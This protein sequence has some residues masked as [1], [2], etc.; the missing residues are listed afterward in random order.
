[1]Y[2]GT[3]RK[4]Y[5]VRWTTSK[6]FASSHFN[7]FWEFHQQS[8]IMRRHNNGFPLALIFF[9][10]SLR[11]W[12]VDQFPVGSSARI[13]S[14]FQ[15]STSQL[16]FSSRKLMRHFFAKISSPLYSLLQFYFLWICPVSSQYKSISI[17][18]A[19]RKF[20]ILKND[21]NLTS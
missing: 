10:T 6:I 9:K 21:S 4:H 18:S 19:I 8:I 7:V 12:F 14:G 2:I 3:R 17:Y 5:A 11:H 20:E 16:L 1:L 13:N 15:Q